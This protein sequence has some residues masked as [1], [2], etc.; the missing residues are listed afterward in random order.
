MG[1]ERP[2]IPRKKCKQL[3]TVTI[4]AEEN[5]LCVNVANET[6]YFDNDEALAS[7]LDTHFTNVS[8]YKIIDRRDGNTNI[9]YRHYDHDEARTYT[10]EQA[11]YKEV[12]SYFDHN[13]FAIYDLDQKTKQYYQ[14][15]SFWTG[16]GYV[17]VS[18]DEARERHTHRENLSEKFTK[19][20]A[21]VN[22]V[23][24]VGAEVG[25]FFASPSLVSESE[26]TIE[27][28]EEDVRETVNEKIDSGPS[29]FLSDAIEIGSNALAHI[30]VASSINRLT[31]TRLTDS[32]WPSTASALALS[33]LQYPLASEAKPIA[34]GAVDDLALVV[35]ESRNL[36]LSANDVF[37]NDFTDDH[38]WSLRAELEN[39]Q[40]LPEW[41]E[42]EFGEMSL[43][44]EY[45]MGSVNSVLVDGDYLYEG[46]DYKGLTIYD[47]A[48]EGCDVAPN[49]VGF[50]RLEAKIYKIA[51][52]NNHV[53]LAAGKSGVI[54][55][56]VSNRTAP[57]Y[58]GSLQTSDARGVTAHDSL[59]FISDYTA[60]IKIADPNDVADIRLLSS[61]DTGGRAN[62][63]VINGNYMYLADDFKGVAVIYIANVESPL[64]I[65]HLNTFVATAIAVKGEYL[66][67][68]DYSE[69]I[70]IISISSAA[71]PQLIY[72][73]DTDGAAFNLIIEDSLLY[74]ANWYGGVKIIDVSLPENPQIIGSVPATWVTDIAKKDGH[75]YVALKT[76]GLMTADVATPTNPITKNKIETSG[77]ASKITPH[78][79]HL[80]I[81]DDDSVIILRN[82]GSTNP[83]FVSRTTFDDDPISIVIYNNSAYMP[84]GAGGLKKFSLE[85]MDNPT[86]STE[87]YVNEVYDIFFDDNTAYTAAGAEGIV[88][89]DTN[90]A[91]MLLPI[92]NYSANAFVITLDIENNFLFFVEIFP[93]SGVKALD[94][95]QRLNPIAIE[96]SIINGVIS[97]F[98]V[99]N[100]LLYYVTNYPYTFV[101][102]NVTTPSLPIEQNR[103]EL[104]PAQKIVVTHEKHA[105]LAI[106]LQGVTNFDVNDPKNPQIIRTFDTYSPSDLALQG[107]HIFVADQEAGVKIIDAG[108][109]ILRMSPS[110]ADVGEYSIRFIADNGH[111]EQANIVFN[112]VVS[113]GLVE[114]TSAAESTSAADSTS[115]AASSTQTASAGSTSADT[116][117]EENSD[118]T[119]ANSDSTSG[120]DPETSTT[121][122]ATKTDEMPEA[123]EEDSGI[124]ISSTSRLALTTG[125]DM[126]TTGP[127]PR[128]DWPPDTS[129]K[130]TNVGIYALLI[131]IC[132]TL[133][134]AGVGLGLFLGY[135]HRRRFHRR[136]AH[137]PG[138]PPGPAPN[139]STNGKPIELEHILPTRS[140]QIHTT[141]VELGA[142][143]FD[144]D[145][146]E[147]PLYAK[148]FYFFEKI[149]RDIA[150]LIHES[151]GYEFYFRKKETIV[152]G[153]IGTGNFGRVLFAF[154]NHEQKVVLVKIIDDEDK[155]DTCAAEANIMNLAKGLKNVI[156]LIDYGKY[157]DERTRKNCLA[158]IMHYANFGNAS[159]LKLALQ[160]F[161][162]KQWHLKQN[163]IHY[164]SNQILSGFSALH[165]RNLFHLD[166]KLDNVV[167]D[168]D[169]L[170]CIPD[171]IITLVIDFGC[172]KEIKDGLLDSDV[173][174]RRYF[175]LKRLN[176]HLKQR[177]AG[178]KAGKLIGAKEDAWA[179][180]LMLYEL[181]TGKNGYFAFNIRG[182]L[183]RGKLVEE[184]E[185]QEAKD[186]IPELQKYKK[187]SIYHLIDD[188]LTV[189]DRKRP[190][191]QDVLANH[192]YF[193]DSPHRNF[194]VEK[195]RQAF[196]LLAKTFE[197]MD[198]SHQF[199]IEEELPVFLE[200]GVEKQEYNR[201]GLTQYLATGSNDSN[202]VPP[203]YQLT[204]N[205]HHQAES[206]AK[207]QHTPSTSHQAESPAEY[208][209]TPT[210][211]RH[212][213]SPAEYQATPNRVLSGNVPTSKR[214][215]QPGY[216]VHEVYT[217]IPTTALNIRQ[218]KKHSPPNSKVHLVP[219]LAPKLP[220]DTRHTQGAGE[221][222]YVNPN[223]TED[224]QQNR[225]PKKRNDIYGVTRIIQIPLK[226]IQ[227]PRDKSTIYQQIPKQGA[228]KSSPRRK[229]KNS[230]QIPTGTAF[231]KEEEEQTEEALIPARRRGK[232]SPESPYGS[233]FAYPKKHG[234]ASVPA[235]PSPAHKE[236]VLEDQ[237]ES[238][239]STDHL[240]WHDSPLM[241]S[242]GAFARSVNHR[243]VTSYPEPM[244][245]TQ[246]DEWQ[247]SGY[248]AQYG[249][250][251]TQSTFPRAE[252]GYA[253]GGYDEFTDQG[254]EEDDDRP[255]ARYTNHGR[256]EE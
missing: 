82:N 150:K 229:K 156:Q 1:R 27:T 165:S 55:V 202:D 108:Q 88:I 153:T 137:L 65:K 176:F 216:R 233:T 97:E 181:T 105:Y 191:C 195:R 114:A 41:M 110:A 73:L 37:T 69:G 4:T 128:F 198:A 113:D 223:D 186:Q 174:D 179:V 28:V 125:A 148:R 118:T 122:V 35:G 255:Y 210:T 170:L 66:Y 116:G 104:S 166:G 171:D 248:Q 173:G 157:Y 215:Q 226:E 188:L 143:N 142:T 6:H 254:A 185:F 84:T 180:G 221:Y 208:Q 163:L 151:V 10:S 239:T 132:A 168:R 187:G 250:T 160:L 22:V 14:Y 241:S 50:Y 62:D 230:D 15:S 126:S 145:E 213:G 101:I 103:I 102:T 238:Y 49:A 16:T 96:E 17:P 130:G 63:A 131:S 219:V 199:G 249:L 228:T 203:N 32:S 146:A 192:A 124:A 236:P 38:P 242:Q 172:S 214:R 120:A 139:P 54:A 3:R 194:P 207:Y 123:S 217:K 167:L 24:A 162:E 209:Y 117:E 231:G 129:S 94:I 184:H 252:N 135:T 23:F 83:E 155:I 134:L 74:L 53:F 72:S 119:D 244:E 68:A 51:I 177:M 36:T 138:P 7:F 2:L 33:L 200:D 169:Q 193:R 57:F 136:T 212:A 218:L 77:T 92:G 18:E 154:D 112:V 246:D 206:P 152:E 149:T 31:P 30:A 147:P 93:R 183:Q 243:D 159:R 107:S 90:I 81:V 39:G 8:I 100:G 56:D 109:R 201:W 106:G 44:G 196:E 70:K 42:F 91:P 11:L 111:G 99:Q 45:L 71:N 85:N 9:S 237:Q 46:S 227:L 86:P 235:A 67:L 164:F 141:Y 21:F 189:A 190:T 80:F 253:Q 220:V 175:S 251:S 224:Y 127:R 47:L 60:G 26:E 225:S 222:D 20:F 247:E 115:A 40:P 52:D 140:F 178:L 240:T 133:T 48:C 76:D 158:I 182:F 144:V 12:V 25:R 29:R 34:M 205:T 58:A 59:L 64:F 197:Q 161:P 19:A 234:A 79:Q 98:T 13:V 95:S 5:I 61:L 89:L 245:P 256:A 121:S 204:P 211:S 78:G 43:A 87:P 232:R 75:V